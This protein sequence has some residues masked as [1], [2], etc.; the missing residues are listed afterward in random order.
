MIGGKDIT[1]RSDGLF[2]SRKPTFD[3]VRVAAP[4]L[5]PAAILRR[6]DPPA[7][8]ISRR[9]WDHLYDPP[10]VAMKVGRRYRYVSGGSATPPT[11][12]SG[13]FIF[14][15]GLPLFNLIKAVAT[16]WGAD[17]AFV[18]LGLVV[19]L[20]VVTF[21][22]ILRSQRVLQSLNDRFEVADDGMWVIRG[23]RRWKVTHPEPARSPMSIH[24]LSKRPILRYGRGWNAYYFDPRLIEED[25]V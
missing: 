3:I 20:L 10:T 11:M 12:Q 21:P 22:L 23:D 4:R 13:V 8:A 6:D 17:E 7:D 16:S 9:F 2:S 25:V 24:N 15:L 19:I 18:W 1:V 5:H 14:M